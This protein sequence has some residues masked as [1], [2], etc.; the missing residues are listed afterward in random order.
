MDNATAS[1]YLSQQH[2]MHALLIAFLLHI[3]AVAVYFSL[4][5][6]DSITIPVRALNIKLGDSE[7][8][9]PATPPATPEMN[10]IAAPTKQQAH[11]ENEST[12]S[13]QSEQEKSYDDAKKASPRRYVRAS[14]GSVY[15]SSARAEAEEMA[16]YEQ[17]ISSWIQ[18][19]KVYPASARSDGIQGEG[20]IRLRISRKGKV[21]FSSIDKSTGSSILDAASLRMVEAANPV[22]KVPPTYPSGAEL[23]FLIPVSFKLE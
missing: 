14:E 15:G 19:H 18:K 5:H 8:I 7:D 21:I 1:P 10:E 12:P 11:K 4:P 17:L 22:P 9:A 6:S 13:E 23:E 20:I 3:F 2:F 16:R